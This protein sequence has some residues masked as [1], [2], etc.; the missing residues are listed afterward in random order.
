MGFRP[1]PGPAVAV[2]GN[3]RK[4]NAMGLGSK[5]LDFTE[6]GGYLR[7]WDFLIIAQAEFSYVNSETF[8]E[9]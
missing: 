7:R 1:K 4:R 5:W 2:A 9:V 6:E 3:G 8:R